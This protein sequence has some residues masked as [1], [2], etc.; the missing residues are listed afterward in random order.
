MV[1]VAAPPKV[2]TM[3]TKKDRITKSDIVAS[4]AEKLGI[5]KTQAKKVL[6]A[7]VE[8][9]IENIANGVKVNLTGF[10]AFELRESKARYGINPRT[11][12]RIR[13]PAATRPA[14][15]AGAALKRAIEQ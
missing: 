2:K 15:R 13:I 9:M 8:V 10:G 14:F 12:E 3:S 7:M 5:P 1:S 11:L 6:D 4:V